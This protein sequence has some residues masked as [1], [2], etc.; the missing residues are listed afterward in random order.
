M[1]DEPLAWLDSFIQGSSANGSL[2][3]HQSNIPV[4]IGSSS[5]SEGQHSPNLDFVAPAGDPPSSS[6]S[7]P[8]S[9]TSRHPPQIKSAS[10]STPTSDR[11]PPRKR[12]RPKIALDPNQ[13]PTVRGNPRARVY[14]ACNQCRIRK[15]R[16][17]GAKPVCFNCHKR[18][19]E[20]GECSY[21]ARPNRRGQDKAPGRRAR[22]ATSHKSK[23]RKTS[24]GTDD[25]N[26]DSDSSSPTHGSGSAS[27][28]QTATHL[29]ASYDNFPGLSTEEESE[30]YDPFPLVDLDNPIAGTEFSLGQHAQEVEQNIPRRPSLQFTRETWWDALLT[31][32]STEFGTTDATSLVPEQ[33][34]ATVLRVVTDLRALFHASIYWVSFVHLPRFFE[35]LLNP[36]TRGSMQPSLVMSALANGLF[37]QSSE[38]ERG[39]AGRAKALKLIEIAH[40]SLQASISSGWVNVELIQAA[41]FIVYFELQSHPMRSASRHRSSLLLLDSLI[42]LF[43]LTTL[44]ADI[45]RAHT[46]NRPSVALL[47]A[48]GLTSSVSDVP[49]NE[50]FHT[51]VHTPGLFAQL[52]SAFPLQQGVNLDPLPHAPPEHVV[53]PIAPENTTLDP[54]TTLPP[55]GCNCASLMLQTHW[56]S[57]S[58]VAP[59]WAGT[60]IWPKNISEGEFRK[61]EC[62][63]LVWSSVMITASLNAYNSAHNIEADIDKQKL[64]IKD[65]DSYALLFPGES[66]A[67]HGV[68]V[69][70]NNVWTLYLRSMLLMHRC[71]QKRADLTLSEAERAQ[72]AVQAWLEIDAIE[73]AL[74]QHTCELEP[75]SR[76]QAREM[77]FSSRMCVSHEFH[78]YIPRITTKGSQL[79]YRDKAEA[80]LRLRMA[81]AERMWKSLTE[82]TLPPAFD[83]R[84]PLLIYWFM[85][86]VLKAL[87][88]W[89]ADPTLIV[90]LEAAKV[91][92]KRTEYL[93]MFWPSEEQRREWGGIRM[94]LVKACLEVGISPPTVALPGPIPHMSRQARQAQSDP[95]R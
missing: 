80:W 14:V 37:S 44:D 38:A 6:S 21:D 17:D 25:D 90:A 49:S 46:F 64:W 84:R 35:A 23:R 5:P 72:F 43:S 88:L 8:A 3:N 48:A 27:G 16:C 68:P 70:P 58:G 40:S 93:M 76:F 81:T 39:A 59:A 19:P 47:N 26:S 71:V 83:Y 29:H 67:M 28:G 41:W 89:E 60:L 22:V 95:T 77:L 50:P 52:S 31:F 42:R 82:G 57:I 1:L 73:D 78:R 30:E 32:Y 87:V 7:T 55:V 51:G 10:S 86:H 4:N 56:P 11:A 9:S 54:S 74:G 53:Q 91:F 13:P 2:P 92:C 18:P 45:K 62:R 12:I 36:T 33:R 66:L 15:T 65:T 94:K 24:S 69:Q 79:F 34:S 63:R 20:V 85:S 75:N 61:E